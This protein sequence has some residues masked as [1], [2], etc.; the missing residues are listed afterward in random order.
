MAGSF[1]LEIATPE[2]LLVS[3]DVTEAQIPGKSGYLGILPEHSPLISALQPGLISYKHG[4]NLECMAVS[5]GY[6]E[7]LP[8]KVTVL[9]ETAE[10]AGEVDVTRAEKARKK[11]EERLKGGA[12]DID[13]TRAA[14][15]LQR[16]LARLQAAGRK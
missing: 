5:W 2:R 9:V 14:A 12:T 7:V 3:T 15:A 4:G 8:G 6:V 10:K 11:A 13:Y 1:K 16:A